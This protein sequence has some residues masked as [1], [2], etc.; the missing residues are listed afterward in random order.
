MKNW[1]FLS[2]YTLFLLSLVIPGIHRKRS[3]VSDWTRAWKTASD[4]VNS[5]MLVNCFCTCLF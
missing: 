1:L 5:Y 4:G 3:D 2:S